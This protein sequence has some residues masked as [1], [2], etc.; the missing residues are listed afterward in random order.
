VTFAE[1]CFGIELVAAASKRAELNDWL[2]H[3]VR[4]MLEERDLPVTEPS[5]LH[6]AQCA[7][8]NYRTGRLLGR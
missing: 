8:E 1:I 6:F 4:P 5:S 3:K 2:A 7:D